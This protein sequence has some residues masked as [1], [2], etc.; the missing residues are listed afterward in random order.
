MR[1][2]KILESM[3]MAH[4]VICENDNRWQYIQTLAALLQQVDPKRFRKLQKMGVL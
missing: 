2:G 1:A 4:D 3:L